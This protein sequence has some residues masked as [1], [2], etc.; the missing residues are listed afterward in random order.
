VELTTDDD[1]SFHAG[2]SVALSKHSADVEHFARLYGTA[3]GVR[4]AAETVR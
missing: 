3:A 2:R 1:D 4:G